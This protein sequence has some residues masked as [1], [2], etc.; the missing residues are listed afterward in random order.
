MLPR[1]G[2]LAGSLGRYESTTDDRVWDSCE[3]RFVVPELAASDA[4]SILE[5]NSMWSKHMRRL[6]SGMEIIAKC[7]S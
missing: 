6:G 2:N 4:T 7:G 3:H 5:T 1:E